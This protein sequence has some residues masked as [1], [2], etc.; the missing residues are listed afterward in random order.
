MKWFF[1][2]KFAIAGVSI[3]ILATAAILFLPRFFVSSQKMNIALQGELVLPA[4]TGLFKVGKTTIYML[5]KTRP[6][7]PGLTDPR[8][9]VVT[10]FYPARP[11]ADATPGP[12]AEQ[13]LS[14]AYTDVALTKESAGVLNHIHSSAY[15]NAT[16]ERS[17]GKFPVLLFSPGGGEQP[18]FYSAL[19]EQISSHGYIVVAVPEPFDTPVIP[20]PDGRVLTKTQM[21]EWCKQNKTCQKGLQGDAAAMQEMMDAMKDDR[22]KDMIF[23][24]DELEK[25][26]REDQVLAGIFD[27]NL[28]GS[29]GHSFGGASAVRVAQLDSRV[30][31]VAVLDSDIFYVIS[32]DSKHLSQPVLYMTAANIDVN[33]QGLEAIGKSDALT[34]AYFRKSAPYFS[35]ILQVQ[36]TNLSR[37][38]PC[39]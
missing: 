35:S 17:A 22:A 1:N 5:D 32:V 33:A 11:N 9:W 7:L 27:L 4:L 2:W 19:L 20:L 14:N 31:S 36:P 38:M 24:L 12:Y 18:L 30:H 16:P 10:I 29:F 25:I 37:L 23:T 26:N 34:S 39:F 6:A 28:V 15:W 21:E 8:E 13:S 3:L